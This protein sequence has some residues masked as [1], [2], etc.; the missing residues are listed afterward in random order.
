MF[1]IVRTKIIFIVVDDSAVANKCHRDVNKAWQVH[2]YDSPTRFYV[3]MI[4]DAH[5]FQCD[6]TSQLDAFERIADLR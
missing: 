4:V 1:D 6:V 2:T 5:G 3:Y